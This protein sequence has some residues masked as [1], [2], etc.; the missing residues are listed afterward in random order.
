MRNF[1]WKV[2]IKVSAHRFSGV[3]SIF[4]FRCCWRLE[5]GVKTL[6]PNRG[7][8]MKNW[9]S[10]PVAIAATQHLLKI[11]E[12]EFW[13][14]NCSQRKINMKFWLNFNNVNWCHLRCFKLKPFFPNHLLKPI[15]YHYSFLITL[16]FNVSLR[17]SQFHPPGRCFNPS[18]INMY[19]FSVLL[20][21][22]ET[23]HA[24]ITKL[25]AKQFLSNCKPHKLENCRIVAVFLFLLPFF[26]A[27]NNSSFPI[28]WSF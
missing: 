6:K 15:E 27:L 8:L 16:A 4:V 21:Q 3:G 5:P 12:M 19:F 13:S 26:W 14:S 2:K 28:F 25:I 18:K 1:I 23:S 9:T 7:S 11:C 20:S 24:F 17:F 10:I 22:I